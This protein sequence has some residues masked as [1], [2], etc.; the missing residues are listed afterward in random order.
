MRCFFA[1]SKF[2]QLFLIAFLFLSLTSY[3]QVPNDDISK[4]LAKLEKVSSTMYQTLLNIEQHQQVEAN[5]LKMVELS[6]QTKLWAEQLYQTIEKLDDEK[7]K[8]ETA[9]DLKEI[10][11]ESANAITQSNNSLNAENDDFR[12]HHLDFLNSSVKDVFDA[13]RLLI[14]YI[15]NYH[16]NN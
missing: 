2:K 3:T 6:T 14:D 12:M 1:N 9:S 10:V 16:N 7:L 8:N 5:L 4:S 13:T 11:R 15:N